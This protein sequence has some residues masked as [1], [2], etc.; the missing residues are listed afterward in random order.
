MTVQGPSAVVLRAN[1]TDLAQPPS[2]VLEVVTL[3]PQEQAAGQVRV[4]NL[5]QQVIA[6]SG[7]LMFA[8]SQIPV[9]TSS[10]CAAPSPDRSAAATAGTPAST[11]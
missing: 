6:A 3:P 10:R 5:F 7:D 2:S 9:P 11:S 1:H 8:T 4:R